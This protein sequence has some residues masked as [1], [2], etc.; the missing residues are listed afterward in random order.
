MVVPYVPALA[1]WMLLPVPAVTIA[2]FSTP[3]RTGANFSSSKKQ[4]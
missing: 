2:Q 3:S 4:Q 1:N